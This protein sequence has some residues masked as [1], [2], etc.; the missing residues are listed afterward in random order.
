[1]LDTTVS[2]GVTIRQMIAKQEANPVL[3]SKGRLE[4]KKLK[5]TN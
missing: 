4:S 1:M 2:T 5:K 3:E